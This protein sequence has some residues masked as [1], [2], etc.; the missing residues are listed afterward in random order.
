MQKGNL[1]MSARMVVVAAV[2]E[3]DGA[4]LVTLRRPGT[5]LADHWEFPG[6]KV[7]PSETH[8]DALRR[9]LREELGITAEVGECLYK[10]THTYPDRT[11]ELYFYRC[12]FRGAPQPLQGQGMQWVKHVDLAALPFPEA[13]RQLIEALSES[14]HSART[15]SWNDP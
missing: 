12:M 2:I 4:F 11:V 14:A 8:I 3:R 13:D 15:V 7:E 1:S 5:H 9:E 6:G 10:V